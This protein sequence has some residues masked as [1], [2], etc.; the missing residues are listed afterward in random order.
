MWAHVLLSSACSYVA[1]V[2][3]DTCTHM[4]AHFLLMYMCVPVLRAVGSGNSL[5]QTVVGDL[6]CSFLV[7]VMQA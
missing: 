4:Y 7:T 5:P 1:S 6:P 3:A 2:I